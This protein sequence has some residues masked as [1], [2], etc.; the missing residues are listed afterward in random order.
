M[1][2]FGILFF[3]CLPKGYRPALS[4]PKGCRLHISKSLP[5]RGLGVGFCLSDCK[6]QFADCRLRI[7]DCGLQVTDCR[8]ISDGVHF[9]NTPCSK[10][11]KKASFC[12]YSMTF[13]ASLITN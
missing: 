6:L 4:M 8:I 3:Y 5:C 2:Y 13:F 10:G 1:L 12:K 7:A 11:L 9:G